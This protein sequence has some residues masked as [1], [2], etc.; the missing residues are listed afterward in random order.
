MV[1]PKTN[2]YPNHPEIGNFGWTEGWVQFNTAFN[3]SMAYLANCETAIEI[4]RKDKRRLQIRLRAPLNFEEDQTDSV[5]L[6]LRSSNGASME[7]RL[8]EE[9]KFSPYLSTNVQLKKGKIKYGKQH[10]KMEKNDT[11]SISYG[12]GYFEKKAFWSLNN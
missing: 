6:N 7:L 12:L 9:G 5:L 4:K 10:I 11:L 8:I 3:T 2:H 1:R